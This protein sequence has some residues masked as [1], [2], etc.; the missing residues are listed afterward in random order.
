MRSL[1]NRFLLALAAGHFIVDVNAN[2]LPIM[3]P[4]FGVTRCGTAA[5]APTPT[6]PHR[7]STG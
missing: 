6:T 3:L 1:L 5:S 7:R 4:F 2:L